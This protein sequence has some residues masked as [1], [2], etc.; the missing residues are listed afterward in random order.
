MILDVMAVAT[1]AEVV[2]ARWKSEYKGIA[3]A[4]QQTEAEVR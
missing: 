2:S 3:F 1:G 4:A